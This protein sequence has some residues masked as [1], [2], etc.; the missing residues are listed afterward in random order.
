MEISVSSSWILESWTYFGSPECATYNNAVV[1]LLKGDENR[2][3]RE[4]TG[5]LEKRKAS[6]NIDGTW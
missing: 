3:P 4:G 2:G 6:A 5:L 1:S